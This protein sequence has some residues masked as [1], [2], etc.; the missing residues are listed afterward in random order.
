ME[1]NP[2]FPNACYDLVVIA[3]SAGGI[4]ALRQL[5]AQLPPEFPAAVAVVQHL[6]CGF[7]SNLANV[8]QHWSRMR[9]KFAA[10]GD[11]LRAGTV[12]IAPPDRHLAIDDAHRFSLETAEKIR[13]CRPSADQLFE[14]A[15]AA[16]HSRVVGV[17][18]TGMGT[19]GALG[20]AAIRRHGGIVIVQ[21]PLTAEAPFMPRAAIAARQADLVLPL[22][23]I[24][25]ALVSLVMVP[26]AS[27]LLGCARLVA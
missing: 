26:G 21:D 13:F 25:D 23:T 17:V 3:A 4:P 6:A 18:L 7:P 2:K 24:S 5:L 16:C 15:A 1:H 11:R 20:A 12:S 9:V 10:Q 22:A 19:D 14:T 8:L 27:S